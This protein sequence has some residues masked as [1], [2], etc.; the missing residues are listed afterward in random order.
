MSLERIGQKT[1]QGV[2]LPWAYKAKLGLTDE[3]VRRVLML[4]KNLIE[5]GT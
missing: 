5:L 1:V 4:K 3:Q 2:A